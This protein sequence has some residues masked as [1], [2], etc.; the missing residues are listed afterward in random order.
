MWHNLKGKS[1]FL[2]K[3]KNRSCLRNFARAD[4]IDLLDMAEAQNIDIESILGKIMT[5]VTAP[6]GP[7]ECMLW[8]GAC[9]SVGKYGV[10][11]NPLKK[12]DNQPN[13]I[14]THRLVYLSHH[15]QSYPT[16]QLPIYD[17]Y[18]DSPVPSIGVCAKPTWIP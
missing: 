4:H 11:R 17:R 14:G 16:Y 9:W 15:I 5:H 6:Q 10:M 13:R 2:G 8:T 18:G 1:R 12:I 7:F 3:V